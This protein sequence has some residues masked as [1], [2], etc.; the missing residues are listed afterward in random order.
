[1]VGS[2][3][4]H[5]LLEAISAAKRVARSMGGETTEVGLTYNC[6]TL[7]EYLWLCH[8]LDDGMCAM[9]AFPPITGFVR[10]AHHGSNAKVNLY[11]ATVTVTCEEIEQ[12]NQQRRNAEQLPSIMW[13]NPGEK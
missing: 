2:N 5:E 12:H 3:V 13:H 8:K 1:M 6:K 4:F 9:Y 10:S 11:G 7:D